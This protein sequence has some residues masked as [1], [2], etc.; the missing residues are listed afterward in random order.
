M[1]S[2]LLEM[3]G[4]QVKP[5]QPLRIEVLYKKTT[6]YSA[7]QGAE[8]VNS[9]LLQMIGAQVQ[10]VRTEVLY[11]KTTLYSAGQGAE[12]VYSIVASSR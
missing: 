10:P 11:I 9:G 8:A 7:G 1:Y 3:T 12:A 4:I 5:H 2:G 6:L